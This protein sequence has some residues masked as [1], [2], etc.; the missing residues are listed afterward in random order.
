M[1]Q[2]IGRAWP[3]FISHVRS[4]RFLLI[5][6]TIIASGLFIVLEPSKW[7]ARFDY[8]GMSPNC[9]YK[10]ET[11]STFYSIDY[12]FVRLYDAQT[13]RLIGESNV[14][15]LTGN[16]ETFWPNPE[17]RPE[18]TVGMDIVIPLPVEPADPIGSCIKNRRIDL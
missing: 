2:S 6:V 15:F 13:G 3:R 10:L 8:Q 9:H 4:K 1:N 16:A 5:V 12:G 17:W 7:F 18:L 11:W 14:A